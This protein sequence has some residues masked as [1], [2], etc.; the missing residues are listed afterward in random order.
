MA[1]G[2]GPKNTKDELQQEA[3][4]AIDQTGVST[5]GWNPDGTLPTN[6]DV[7]TVDDVGSGGVD[8]ASKTPKSVSGNGSSVT[9]SGYIVGGWVMG[10]PSEF[11]DT[12]S[13]AV[14]IDSGSSLTLCAGGEGNQNAGRASGGVGALFRFGSGFDVSYNG[15]VV[16]SGGVLY[17]LD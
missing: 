7:A 10:S 4:D 12:V 16:E 1:N 5:H 2:S 17:V 11:A 3:Q 6:S 13:L 14:T 15:G 8:W 9:G